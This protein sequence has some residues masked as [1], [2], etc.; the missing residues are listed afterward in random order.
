[1]SAAAAKIQQEA[2]VER[3][4]ARQ[5]IKAERPRRDPRPAEQVVARPAILREAGFRSARAEVGT[6]LDDKRCKLPDELKAAARRAATAWE[7]A[8]RIEGV[9]GCLASLGGPGAT[10]GEDAPDQ[11]DMLLKRAAAARAWLGIAARLDTRPVI[12]TPMGRYSERD[13]VVEICCK[14]RRITD[15]AGGKG[16]AGQAVTAA[17]RAGLERLCAVPAGQDF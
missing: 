2:L 6:P 13:V 5:R 17:L 16:R 8:Q 12:D 9:R 1:M 14:G 11:H 10:G 4:A 3:E 15:V 7:A